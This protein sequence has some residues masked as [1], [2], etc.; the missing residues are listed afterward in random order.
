MLSA[1]N[2][3][4]DL[5]RAAASGRIGVD[6]RLVRSILDYGE[7]ASPEIL[8]FAREPRNHHRV[9]LDPLLID[10]F[11]YYH[12]PEAVDFFMDAI[13]RAPEDVDESLIQAL[14]P[15]GEKAV[16]P[17]L[18][19]YEELGE[20]QGTDVAFLLASL[21]VHDPRVLSLLL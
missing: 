7:A 11:R 9:D 1:K 8:A 13:R 18:R 20:E 5:L 21:R 12:T 2:N 4:A 10:L 16:D 15:F 3:I 19:L 6:R 14:L 17:M